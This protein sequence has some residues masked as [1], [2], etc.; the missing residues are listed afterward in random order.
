M[1]NMKNKKIVWLASYP[2]SGNTWVRIFLSNYFS[3]ENIPIDIN[4][5]DK[6]PIFSSR[7]VFDQF[8]PFFSSDL[9]PDEIDN[10]RFEIYKKIAIELTDIQF[11]KIHD[12]FHKIENGKNLFPTEFTYG[13]IYI[14]R[15]PLDV[16]VSFAHHSNITFQKSCEFLCN[17]NAVF[18][19]SIYKMDSQIRQ[20]VNS[21]GDHV[22][23]WTENSD[24]PI[25][26]IKYEDL[27]EN[28]KENF[29]KILN[30]L[31]IKVIEAKFLQSIQFSSFSELKKQE[32]EK[33][34]LEK[35]INA[36]AFFRKGKSNSWKEELSEAQVEFI[37]NS[38]FDIMKKYSYI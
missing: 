22:M 32:C 3:L 5:L 20:I 18:A 12:S 36:E 17:H 2:K 34:F 7:L 37:I 35:P 19:K 10:L 28:P 31:K 26:L 16:A 38:N 14:I 4:N 27:V 8:S 13:A 15:N 29:R 24:F 11:F 25:L 21:W 6:S 23:S 33:G 9:T 1:P 30:F